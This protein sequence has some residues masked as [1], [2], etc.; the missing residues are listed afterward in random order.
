MDFVAILQ[1][2]LSGNLKND[3]IIGWTISSL[4]REQT[5]GFSG[6]VNQVFQ[7]SPSLEKKSRLSKLL[8]AIIHV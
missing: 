4:L 1:R 2:D 7:A 6:T 8:L 5:A 3:L